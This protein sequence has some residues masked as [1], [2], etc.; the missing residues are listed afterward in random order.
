MDPV[1][2]PLTLRR[3]EYLQEG[4][5]GDLYDSAKF[6]LYTLEHAYTVDELF[7]GIPPVD[8]P[9]SIIKYYAKIPA[10]VYTCQLGT[11]AGKGKFQGMHCL[12][13]GIW[14]NAYQIMNVPGHTNCLFHHGNYN[15]DSDGCALLGV[16]LG[17]T[18]AMGRMLTSS[19]VGVAQFMKLQNGALTFRLTV[20]DTS[21][22]SA[23]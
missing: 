2:I 22:I 20:E 18:S 19:D 7:P 10:G 5:I 23:T 21:D 17:R 6:H 12:H 11:G 3:R 9:P 8:P 1:G 4:I 15:R 16:G 14:F 13:D